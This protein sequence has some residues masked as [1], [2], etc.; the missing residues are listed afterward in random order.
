[1]PKHCFLVLPRL[2][3]SVEVCD[4]VELTQLVLRERQGRDRGWWDQMLSTFHPD[5]TIS[6]S[7][8]N[9]T[10]AEFVERSKVLFAQGVRPTH[11][12]AGSAV[13]VHAHRAV[14]E[15]PAEIHITFPIDGVDADLVNYARLLYQAEKLESEWKIR[16]LN[17]IYEHDTLAPSVVGTQLSV[18]ADLL[19]N[20]RP[21]YRHLGYHLRLGGLPVRDDLYGDDRPA[22]VEAL[23]TSVFEWS[24]Q[25]Q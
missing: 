19:G 11:R 17:V 5:A 25:E 18:D 10:A 2:K 21:S 9:S 8:L 15:A 12:I 16:A 20:T 13:H 23:Y 24:R 3:G 6:L 4:V 22:D 14:V 7:W 1:M